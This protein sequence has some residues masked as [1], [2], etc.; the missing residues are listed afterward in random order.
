MLGAP[1]V[2]TGPPAPNR[3]R[4][5]AIVGGI[6]AAVALVG[7]LLVVTGGDDEQAADDT[8][9]TDETEATDE[10]EPEV[11]A[12]PTI[13][14]T[15]VPATAVAPTTTTEVPTTTEAPTTA[16]PT[17]L[18][19]TAPPLV[20]ATPE[21]LIAAL[22]TGAD[23]PADWVD[24]ENG[25]FSAPDPA[26]GF[27]IGLCGG[28][29]ADARAAAAGGIAVAFSSNFLPPYSGDFNVS[30]Y[31]FG[32]PEQASAFL[33]VTSSQAA[34]CTAGIQYQLP[35]GTEQ[36]QYWGFEEGVDDAAI[37]N[38]SEAV[39]PAAD[40]VPG[41]DEALEVALINNYTTRS[42]GIDYVVNETTVSVYERYGS[43]VVISEVWG[44]YDRA[45]FGDVDP[46]T[47]HAPTLEDAYGA[48]ALVRPS[49]LARLRAQSLIV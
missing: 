20:P 30:L 45:G 5:L 22:P 15:T 1:T 48:A 41:A 8:E 7:G 28:D 37:W 35:Q 32:A 29:N 21:A 39:Y 46:T 44:W 13:V 23:L 12:A 34:T 10:T 2:T 24:L 16:V 9:E 49:I 27:G 26:S 17:T 47:E 11:T 43:V 31:A 6:V 25:P 40:P 3:R 18:P 19:T 38:V 14:A 4:T 36:G 42:G 33:A